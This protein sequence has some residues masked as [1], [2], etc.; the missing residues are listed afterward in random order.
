MNPIIIA[1]IAVITTIIYFITNVNDDR[2]KNPPR[3]VKGTH[4]GGSL[5][6]H[7]GGHVDNLIN[8]IKTFSHFDFYTEINLPLGKKLSE[9]IDSIL[10]TKYPFP[11]S[12]GDMITKSVKVAGCTNN[13]KGLQSVASYPK[14]ISPSKIFNIVKTGDYIIKSIDK[15]ADV[16]D[17]AFKK[18]KHIYLLR[19]VAFPTKLFVFAADREVKFEGGENNNYIIDR[20]ENTYLPHYKKIILDGSMRAFNAA[21]SSILQD[22]EGILQIFK[23]IIDSSLRWCVEHEISIN[24]WYKQNYINT[25]S[26]F[27]TGPRDVNSD[28]SL[29]DH[30][31][32]P[33]E[34][35]DK[36][37]IIYTDESIY[38][39]TMPGEAE[40]IDNFI[41]TALGIEYEPYSSMDVSIIDGTAGI[42]GNTLSFAR[43]FKRVLSVEVDD[44]N[45]AALTNNINIVYKSAIKAADLQLKHASIVEVLK[46]IREGEFDVLSLDPP[47]GGLTYRYYNKLRLYFENLDV[48]DLIIT[49]MRKFKI[50]TLKVPPNFDFEDFEY[51]LKREKWTYSK[52]RVGKTVLLI[53]RPKL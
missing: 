36:S 40:Q 6:A 47:W 30:L 50:V 1:I 31:F 22:K 46:E 32:P 51:K 33:I 16:D 17:T 48:V 29:L 7:I 38:G 43:D 3:R 42:G 41:A 11:L 23:Y 8:I 9:S 13:F 18:Y 25:H 27:P 14:I 4:I 34:G 2:T 28:K 20:V 44:E 52:N 10:T 24:K 49:H 19:S 12:W 26:I 39:T 37:K 21:D 45:F 53:L 35:V 5:G 15:A